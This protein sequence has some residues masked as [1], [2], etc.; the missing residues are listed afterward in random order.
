MTVTFSPMEIEMLLEALQ[1]AA[2]RHESSARYMIGRPRAT[3]R[4]HDNKAVAMRKLRA[5]LI[6]QQT[7]GHKLEA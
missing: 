6:S 5:R 1:M 2:S 3:S 4:I 7:E